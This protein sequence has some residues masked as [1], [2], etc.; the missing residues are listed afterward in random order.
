MSV[1]ERHV[2]VCTR[3]EWCPSI[4]GDGIGVHAALKAA[5]KAAGL[6]DRVRVNH[7]GCFSQCG[8]GPMAVV[9]PD[10]VWYAALTPEDAEEIVLEHLVGGRPV[11]RLRYRPAGMGPHKLERDGDG[12]PIGRH[13]SW[14]A[15]A[16]R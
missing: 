7:A 3:G 13:D 14:P 11:E 15:G 8:N 1:F 9:Y 5:A 12:R 16:E 4:D 10:D 6:G 2:F